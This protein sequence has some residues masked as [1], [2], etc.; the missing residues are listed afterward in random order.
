MEKE[1]E[2]DASRGEE[3]TAV[4]HELNG[5]ELVELGNTT[6]TVSPEAERKTEGQFLLSPLISDT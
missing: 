4:T 1:E 3:Q 6:T 5:Q 2:Q